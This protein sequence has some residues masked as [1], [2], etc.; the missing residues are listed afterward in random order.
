MNPLVITVIKGSVNLVGLAL[1]SFAIEGFFDAKFILEI[2]LIFV[3]I[4]TTAALVRY[5]VTDLEK[6]VVEITTW[7]EDH[8]DEV[9]DYKETHAALHAEILKQNAVLRQILDDQQRRIT[10]LE[11]ARWREIQSRG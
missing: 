7:Q 8:D 10:E 6:T 11:A 3:G 2:I 4:V 5:R 1:V 9:K